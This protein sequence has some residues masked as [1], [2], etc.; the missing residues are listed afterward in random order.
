MSKKHLKGKIEMEEK[1]K[2]YKYIIQLP[3]VR[4]PKCIY[5]QLK[6]G[7]I[8]NFLHDNKE[9]FLCYD[10]EYKYLKGRY[11]TGRSVREALAGIIIFRKTGERVILETYEF[12][13][14][15]IKH[16]KAL[17]ILDSL[18]ALSIEKESGVLRN[19][20]HPD[21]L[22][23][24]GKLIEIKSDSDDLLKSQKKHFPKICKLRS[25]PIYSMRIRFMTETKR[26]E[27]GINSIDEWFQYVLESIEI[28]F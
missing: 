3:T 10:E 8:L 15:Q 6:S 7:K 5:E 22:T 1:F 18:V 4:I 26:K 25:K 2:N 24:F 21:I 14:H 20:M 12:P 28:E 27:L 23:E 17:K 19:P 11:L 13:R 16:R 9:A